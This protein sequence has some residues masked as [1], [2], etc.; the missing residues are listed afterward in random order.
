MALGIERAGRIRRAFRAGMALSGLLVQ[1]GPEKVRFAPLICK[2]IYEECCQTG[3]RP[4]EKREV[5]GPVRALR[6]PL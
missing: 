4:V 2:R 5:A 3:A 1:A 6:G